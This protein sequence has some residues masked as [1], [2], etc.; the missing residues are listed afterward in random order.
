MSDYD[1]NDRTVES[2]D[3]G[4]V[5]IDE[6]LAEDTVAYDVSGFKNPTVLTRWVKGFLYAM[7]VI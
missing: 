7:I 3:D 4:V 2:V 5:P 1:E 6:Q